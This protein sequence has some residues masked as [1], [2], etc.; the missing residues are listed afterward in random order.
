MAGPCFDSGLNKIAV[1]DLFFTTVG[2]LN[3]A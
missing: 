1:K 2:N 3:M